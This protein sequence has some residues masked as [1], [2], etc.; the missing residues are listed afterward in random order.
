MV[1]ALSQGGIVH[2]RRILLAAVM[3][4]GGATAGLLASTS[5]GA[6]P[7]G[8]TFGTPA[9]V[10]PWLPG[11]EPDVAVDKSASGKGLLYTS[12]PNGF[13]TT[14]SYINR[15]NDAGRSFHPTEANILG[16]PITCAGGGDTDLQVSPV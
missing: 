13:S 4:A 16:K 5:A 2:R 3:L 14:I 10:N 6:T 8:P 7:A 9:V 12:W 1:G 11:N 15:S